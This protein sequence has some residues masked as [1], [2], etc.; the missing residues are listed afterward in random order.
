ML[1]TKN[2]IFQTKNI[3]NKNIISIEFVESTMVRVTKTCNFKG[4]SSI[5]YIV[6]CNGKIK[7][8]LYKIP[9]LHSN[10]TMSLVVNTV[11]KTSQGDI[12]N[13]LVDIKRLP[14]RP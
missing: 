6:L 14:K 12:K 4:I 8:I 1:V 13:T 3:Q 9:R 10:T 7:R 5:S 2:L 11:L